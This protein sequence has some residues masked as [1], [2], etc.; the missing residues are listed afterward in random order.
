MRKQVP[1]AITFVVGVL[2]IVS[3]FIPHP[4]FDTLD[5]DLST[6]FNIL[7]AFALVLGAGNLLQI[8]MGAMAKQKKGWGFSAVTVVGFFVT[9]IF[10]LFKLGNPAGITGALEEPGSYFKWLYDFIFSPLQATMFS[11]LAFFVASASYRA[12]RAKSREA[13]MLLVAAFVI[14][15]G[16]TLLQGVIT[17]WMPGAV[18]LFFGLILAFVA[19]GQFK[20]KNM[21]GAGIIGLVGAGLIVFGL[22]GFFGNLGDGTVDVLT[23]PELVSWIMVTPQLAGQRAIMIGICLGVISMSLRIIM[24]VERS[25]LGSDD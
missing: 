24:G 20:A 8:H 5:S 14:L 22:Y 9:L 23:I 15:M 13:T 3:S 19:R 17:D 4:P 7:A 2:M 10:G 1:L 11:L 16:R 25:H 6:H 12:F 18:E 21:I